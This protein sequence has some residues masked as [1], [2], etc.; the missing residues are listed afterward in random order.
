[1]LISIG[2]G[3][4]MLQVLGEWISFIVYLP[5]W[6]SLAVIGALFL[7]YDKLC[8][9]CGTVT[10][11][12]GKQT[13]TAAVEHNSTADLRRPSVARLETANNVKEASLP[14]STPTD[15]SESPLSSTEESQV[16]K[17]PLQEV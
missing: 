7:P 15:Q 14:V 5:D 12:S 4:N 3:V 16:T 8:S 2:V 11:G 9:C 17:E 1:M 10:N 6:I 13:T